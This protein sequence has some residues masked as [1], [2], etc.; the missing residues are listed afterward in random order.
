VLV[1]TSLF[2][3]TGPE[4]SL[5]TKVTGMDGMVILSED[6]QKLI[7]RT[8]A[9]E[10]HIYSAF[11]GSHLKKLNNPLG[12]Y[13]EF[14][15]RNDIDAVLFQKDPNTILAWSVSEDRKLHE[16]TIGITHADLLSFSPDGKT[17]C[18]GIPPLA[19][20]DTKTGQKIA[21]YP[22]PMT[23]PDGTKGAVSG[24]VSQNY[25]CSTESMGGATVVRLVYIPDGSCITKMVA[26][27]CGSHIA[28]N[29]DEGLFAMYLSTTCVVYDPNPKVRIWKIKP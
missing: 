2:D 25:V 1:G 21:E 6:G 17:F 3:I 26:I 28:V 10:F 23:F 8:A 19:Y 20:F 16:I 11:D 14:S 24:P 13:C 9:G 22:H 5:I 18:N 29:A 27:P 4:A 15:Y 12:A 7:A